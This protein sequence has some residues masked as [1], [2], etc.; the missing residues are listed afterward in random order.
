MSIMTDAPPI[1]CT[2][3]LFANAAEAAR[4]RRVEVDLSPGATA[5][6]ALDEL[7]RLHPSLAT[8]RDRIGLAVNRRYVR[9][10]HALADGDELALIPPVSGG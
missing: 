4:T 2:V 6:A 3:L 5:G 7:C 8:L 9:D 10:D 1:R